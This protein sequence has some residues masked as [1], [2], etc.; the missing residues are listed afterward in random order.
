M[1]VLMHAVKNSGLRLLD[2]DQ[3]YAPR[4]AN[5]LDQAAGEADN[6][7]LAGGSKAQRNRA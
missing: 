2:E 6:L 4:A 7:C 3:S 5:R 1:S